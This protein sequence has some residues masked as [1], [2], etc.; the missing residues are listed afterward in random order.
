MKNHDL[1][2]EDLEWLEW[3]LPFETDLYEQLS[4][5][6]PKLS[7]KLPANVKRKMRKL[8]MDR[9]RRNG[10]I[11]GMNNDEYFDEYH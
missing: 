5:V 6:E 10:E 4:R 2:D 3:N 9:L 8:K 1:T 7:K 11:S